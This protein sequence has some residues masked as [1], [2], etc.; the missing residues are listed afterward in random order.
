MTR[1]R[2]H[3]R[4]RLAAAILLSVCTWTIPVRAE[5]ASSIAAEADDPWSAYIAEASQRFGVPE[6]WIRSVMQVESGGDV[7][8]VSPKGAMGLM[9]IMPETW[10]DLR[11]RYGLGADPYDPRDNILAGAAYLREMHDRYGYPAV[12]AA[13]NAGPRRVDE[14]LS[15]GRPLPAE[16]RAYLA[17]L[18]HADI[19]RERSPVVA[20]TLSLF[21]DLHGAGRG[22]AF[23]PSS[24][25]GLFVPVST[26]RKSTP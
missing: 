17:A 5:F 4:V 24:A 7:R 14:H 15:D 13:Y 2:S 26:A 20:S 10:A 19:A 25:G 16:T 6:P 8:A 22:V 12:F 3:R 21:V 9:Q 23:R 18:G 1:I 11:D